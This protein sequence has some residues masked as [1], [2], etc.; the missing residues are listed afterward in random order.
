MNLSGRIK[1]LE[2]AANVGG[3]CLCF[4]QLKVEAILSRG[5]TGTLMKAPDVCEKCRKPVDK[6]FIEVTFEQ[7]VENV[8]QRREQARRT[9][10]LFKD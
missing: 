4:G 9:M 5:M 2:K 6:R 7:Y 1:K 3:F 10:E 8:R